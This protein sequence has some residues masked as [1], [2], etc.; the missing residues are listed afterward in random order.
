MKLSLF[1]WW[2]LFRLDRG[3]GRAS[4]WCG[5]SP[6]CYATMQVLDRVVTILSWLQFRSLNLQMLWKWI[7][8]CYLMCGSWNI[9]IENEKV[10]NTIVLKDLKLIGWIE[11]SEVRTSST[12]D[13]SLSL[14][15]FI[16]ITHTPRGYPV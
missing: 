11:T 8:Y 4:N 16:K 14:V 10:I 9:V 1:L 5:R 13:R 3:I 2:V 7:I 6:K 12:L 15:V